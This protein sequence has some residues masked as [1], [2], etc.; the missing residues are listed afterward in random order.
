MS[1]S[2]ACAGGNAFETA[3]DAFLGFFGLVLVPV[4]LIVVGVVLFLQDPAPG[5]VDA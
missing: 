4:W 2:Y 1:S 5:A 3:A